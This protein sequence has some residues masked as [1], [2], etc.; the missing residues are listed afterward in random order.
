MG[1]HDEITIER[2]LIALAATNGSPTKAS[3][4]LAEGGVRVDKSSIREWKRKYPDRYTALR[5]EVL[6]AVRTQAA[7][8]HME[9]AAMQ[10]E[11]N[12]KIVRRMS[13]EVDELPVK[14]L[15]GASR[16]MSVSSGVETDKAQLL[17]DQPTSRVAH[18]LPGVLKEL[19]EMGIEFGVEAVVEDAEV[20]EEMPLEAV[21]SGDG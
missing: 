3:A 9:L 21:G 5:A 13:D 10:M 1:R 2:A 14:E 4:L 15:P 6:P 18:N 11:V 17:N 8:E 16:N 12:R 20:V 7:D 19:K